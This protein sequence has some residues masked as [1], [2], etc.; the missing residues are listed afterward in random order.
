MSEYDKKAVILRMFFPGSNG[1][2]EK[3]ERR[4][5]QADDKEVITFMD[6]YTSSFGLTG[7][8]VS[9]HMLVAD[10]VVSPSYTH[11]GSYCRTSSYYRTY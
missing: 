1:V 8:A 11:L 4:V 3:V 10:D 2:M 6:S 7:V 5:L 9:I